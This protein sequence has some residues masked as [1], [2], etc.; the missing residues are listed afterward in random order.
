MNIVWYIYGCQREWCLGKWNNATKI[1][2]CCALPALRQQTKT[3]GN[4]AKYLDYIVNIICTFL[5]NWIVIALKWII[6]GYSRNF[7][8]WQSVSFPVL[9]EMIFWSSLNVNILLF[10]NRINFLQVCTWKI[11]WLMLFVTTLFTCSSNKVNKTYSYTDI[12]I[13]IFLS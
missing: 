12:K 1:D 7:K 4:Y 10:K 5:S 13:C 11:S 8:E 6:Y 9:F 2:L 3:H